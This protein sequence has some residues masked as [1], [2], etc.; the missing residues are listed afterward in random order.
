MKNREF[1]EGKM[2]ALRRFLNK[3]FYMN[4]LF[5]T[6]SWFVLK[7]IPCS[8]EFLFFNDATNTWGRCDRKWRFS[9]KETAFFLE[10]GRGLF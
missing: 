5:R 7:T 8:V 3:L 9:N 10:Q 1:T 6:K 2:V 4:F